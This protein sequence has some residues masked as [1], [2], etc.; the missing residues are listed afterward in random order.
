V[1][2]FG[3]A[4]QLC[5]MVPL[6]AVVDARGRRRITVLATLTDRA[7]AADPDAIEAAQVPEG[8]TVRAAARLDHAL[9]GGTI[10]RFDLRVP[11]L[12]DADLT[13]SV[14]H[15]VVPRGKHILMRIGDR[16]LRSHCA[17]TAPGTCTGP[18]ALA[19]AGARRGRSSA[20]RMP[21]PWGSRCRC[22][23]SSPPPARR[24]SS[25]TW[26][27]TRWPTT[28]IRPRPRAVW[29]RIRGR[30][31]S[32]CW[33]SATSRGSAMSTPPSCCSCGASCPRDPRRGGRRSA[34]RS[35]S[36]HDPRQPRP[37]DRTFTGVALPGTVGVR[38]RTP[39]V[40]ALQDADPHG[41]AG[42]RSD[43]EE[44]RTFWCPNCQR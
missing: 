16:T 29:G 20:R 19:G 27:P 43:E 37:P 44:R 14:V 36:A 26:V 1:L 30:S 13:G 15:A 18:Q 39:S 31:T 25:G 12:A 35:G 6:G 22:S 24:S 42:R 17:W 5:F 28:G 23:R 3:V 21:R 38:T 8:D 41:R 10:T 32:P 7:A 4:T 2:G 33:I 11:Q 34:A 40:P 9:R